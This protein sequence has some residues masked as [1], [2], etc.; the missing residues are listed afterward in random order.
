MRIFKLILTFTIVNA[1]CCYSILLDDFNCPEYGLDSNFTQI[2]KNK[3][4]CAKI[5]DSCI[6]FDPTLQNYCCWT[7]D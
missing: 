3:S 2:I 6:T 5:N 4:T 1:A 7:M